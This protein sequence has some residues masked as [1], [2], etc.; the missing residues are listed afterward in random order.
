MRLEDLTKIDRRWVFF[1][2]GLAVTLPLI[3]ALNLPVHVTKEVQNFYDSVEILDERDVVLLSWDFDPSTAAELLPM[4]KALFRHADQGNLRILVTTIIQ[5]APGLIEEALAEA[6]DELGW[7]DGEDYVFLGYKPSLTATAL[8]IGQDI[9]TVFPEDNVGRR[10]ADLPVMDGI[11]NYADIGLM[12][13]ITGT[14][15]IES[16]IAYANAGYGQKI[17]GGATAVMVAEMYPY[18]QTGQL[19]GLLGGL[20]GG[21][22]YEVLVGFRDKAVEGMDAQSAVHIVIILFIVIGNLGYF[23]ERRSKAS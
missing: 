17:V 20:R 16:W 1:V 10:T 4:V 6:S 22:E 18:L 8:G 11:T 15:A 14:S 3:F 12:V 5:G 9:Y 7:V 21:A 19:S 2:V 23:A 13:N